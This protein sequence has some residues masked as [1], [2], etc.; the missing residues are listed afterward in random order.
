MHCRVVLLQLDLS[1]PAEPAMRIVLKMILESDD[2]R[3]L[4]ERELLGIERS[5]HLGGKPP[6]LGMTMK[7]AKA[8]LVATQQA[9]VVGG[10]LPNHAATGVWNNP[11]Q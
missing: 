5:D 8:L 10:E 11:P 6:E 9:V 1:N 4:N 2:A 7:E 3:V